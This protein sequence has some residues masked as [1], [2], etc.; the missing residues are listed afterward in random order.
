V[1]LFLFS[2]KSEKINFYSSNILNS[3]LVSVI[4]PQ[5]IEDKHF[6]F[7]IR[8][9]PSTLFLDL[10]ICWQHLVPDTTSRQMLESQKKIGFWDWSWMGNLKPQK[11]TKIQKILNP[12]PN[13]KFDFFLDF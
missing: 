13:P 8:I 6:F 4:S 5:E 1:A 3:P 2:T 9:G 10:K 7:G 12:N 11:K